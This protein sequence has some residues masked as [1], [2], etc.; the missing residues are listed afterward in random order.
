MRI[1]KTDC[2]GMQ[3]IVTERQARL[4]LGKEKAERLH[5]TGKVTTGFN[6]Y[7]METADYIKKH[8]L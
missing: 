3:N 1:I 5:Q 2:N 4:Q 6:T 7:E 8:C